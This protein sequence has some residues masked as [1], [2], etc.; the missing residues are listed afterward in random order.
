MHYKLEI[1]PG[2]KPYVLYELT[3]KFPQITIQENEDTRTI[4]FES[5]QEDID[6]FYKLHSP[7]RIQKENGLIRNLY[8]RDWKK[9]SVPAGINPSLSYILCMLA[10]I[11]KQDVVFDP[12]CGAGTIAITAKLY[13]NPYKVLCSDISG[14]AL[15]MAIANSKAAGI[16]KNFTAFRSNVSQLRL[17][18]ESVSKIITNMP[19]GIRVGNHEKNKKIYYNFAKKSRVILKKQGKL[20]IYT[21]EKEL[22]RENFSTDFKI[23]DEIII[24]QGG[25]FPTIFVISKTT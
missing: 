20:I 22:I 17:Q 6:V 8:R 25:L 23:E 11:S 10:E 3:S 24:E 18:K 16:T 5:K 1:I 21:Q 4:S 7:L 15:D 14:K 12:F 19:F 2:T 13:F 9:Y